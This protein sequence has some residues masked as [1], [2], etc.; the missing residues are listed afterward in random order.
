M[1]IKENDPTPATPS[2]WDPHG[3]EI[4]KYEL[5]GSQEPKNQKIEPNYSDLAYFTSYNEDYVSNKK[6]AGKP[7][8][9]FL[10]EELLVPEKK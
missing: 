9:L 6:S 5:S 10:K 4:N 3:A 7:P 2:P 1:V 8:A